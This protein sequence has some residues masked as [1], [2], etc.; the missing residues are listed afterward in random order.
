MGWNQHF[1]TSIEKNLWELLHVVVQ[2]QSY[3]VLCDPMDNDGVVHGVDRLPCPAL[4]PKVYSD[5]C[6]L[7][8]WCHPTISS[9]FTPFSSC[10][11]SFPASGSFLMSQLFA[12]VGQST[13]ASASAPALPMNIQDWFPLGLN[14][15]DLLAVQGTLKS[16]PASQFKN[17]YSSVLSLLYGPTLKSIHDYWKKHSFNYTD[18]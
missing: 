12:S 5:S 1:K 7:S 13:G 3:T 18:L 8:W 17:T 16:P 15:L 10:L 2:S 11:Q 9:S 14:G 6:I 4:S